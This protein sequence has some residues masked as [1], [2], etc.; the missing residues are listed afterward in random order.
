MASPASPSSR[1]KLSL[2]TRSVRS[3]V[4]EAF[5][6]KSARMAAANGLPRGGAAGI[7]A[8]AESASAPASAACD[9][10]EATNESIS[11]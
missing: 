3:D 9:E 4:P 8:A 11:A 10:S 1:F 2:V 7:G 5:E 6:G